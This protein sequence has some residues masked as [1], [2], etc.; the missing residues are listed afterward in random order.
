M[1]LVLALDTFDSGALVRPVGLA[2]CPACL[3]ERLCACLSACRFP[4]VPRE[5]C[6]LSAAHADV[7]PFAC[8]GV[9]GKPAT[10]EGRHRLT[11][12]PGDGNGQQGYQRDGEGGGV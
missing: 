5:S 11:L 2:R 8:H 3:A 1:V 4:L 12:H 7:Q 10:A 9:K 6:G